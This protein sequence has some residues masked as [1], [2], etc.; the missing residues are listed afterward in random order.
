VILKKRKNE[1]KRLYRMNLKRRKIIQVIMTTFT[2][3]TGGKINDVFVAL[4]DDGTLWLRIYDDK[5]TW[6]WK[7]IDV[8]E[9]EEFEEAL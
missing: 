5:F 7:Q 4:C 8:T 2:Q 1:R 9:V 6:K 3:E